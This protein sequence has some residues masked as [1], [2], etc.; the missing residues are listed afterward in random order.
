MAH[1]RPVE[2]RDAGVPAARAKR[3][4]IS[5]VDC[6][7]VGRSGFQQDLRETPGRSPRVECVTATDVKA[8]AFEGIHEF[9]RTAETYSLPTGA[10]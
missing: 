9:V 10:R 3:L 5:H 1:I 7:D 2:H 6:H 8:E 4:A